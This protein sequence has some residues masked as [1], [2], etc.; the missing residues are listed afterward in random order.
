MAAQPGTTT[1][2]GQKQKDV[3]NRAGLAMNHLKRKE[4]GH[5]DT[6][7]NKKADRDRTFVAQIRARDVEIDQRGL[8]V[9]AGGE[10]FHQRLQTRKARG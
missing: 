9:A 2:N 4:F 5:T 8:A 3:E 1:G 7:A 6:D 10:V